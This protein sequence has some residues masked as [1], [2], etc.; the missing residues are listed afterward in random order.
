MGV[1]RGSDPPPPPRACPASPASRI[2]YRVVEKA[3]PAASPETHPDP[4]GSPIRSALQGKRVLVTGVTG[5]L[6]AALFERLLADFPQTSV[7]VLIR[8]RFGS[9]PEARLQE[10]VGRNGFSKLRERIGP[11]ALQQAIA[12]RVTVVEGDVSDRVPDLPSGIDTVFHCAAS[13]SFDPPI[14]Q[15]FQTN[16]LGSERLYRAV[17]AGGSRPHLVHVST[18]YVAGVTKGVIPE[19]PLEH[20]VDWRGEAEA[21]LVA[22]AATEDASRKPEVLDRFSRRARAEHGR[23]GPQA[24]ARGAEERR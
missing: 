11:E 7:V 21:A 1:V 12:E 18:A 24:V 19:A 23:A 8:G 15:A 22:R 6:G 2:I 9:S 16:L 17:L 14:D 13:V 20:R 4:S 3:P 10:L 5:F